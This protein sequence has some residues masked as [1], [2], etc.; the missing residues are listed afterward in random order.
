MIIAQIIYSLMNDL[1]LP[2]PDIGNSRWIGEYYDLY[3]K[4]LT[5][6]L[7]SSPS[8]MLSRLSNDSE[9]RMGGGVAEG[10]A[11]AVSRLR[12]VFGDPH[13]EFVSVEWRSRLRGRALRPPRPKLT[14]IREI[15]KILHY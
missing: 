5:T 6:S 11:T 4:N 8:S 3:S 14:W 1:F 10:A 13:D 7:L 15:E 2:F 12:R 9:I